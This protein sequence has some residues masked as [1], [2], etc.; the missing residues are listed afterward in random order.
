M[1]VR[2]LEAEAPRGQTVT[3][4]TAAFT[5][6]A[7][8]GAAAIHVEP[9]RSGRNVSTFR[10]S[11]VRD[12]TVL[13]TALATLARPREGALEHH[14]R[15]MPD[16]PEPLATADGPSEHY[17]PPF[18][19]RFSFRQTHGPRPFSGGREARVA[20]WCRLHEEGVPFDA[21]LVCAILDAW[22]P[23][24]VGLS[25]SWCPV[26]SVE[27]TY[28]FFAPLPAISGDAWVFYDAHAGHVSG[29]LAD[30]H[31]TLWTADG[32]PLATSRQLIAL[33]PA[34]PK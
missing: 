17:I 15:P 21:A 18:A 8:E 30:E 33:F 7:T 5:A 2:A 3:T 14:A 1:L 11:L 28:H 10:G 19:R 31:A 24:A 6:P 34:E 4:L 32:R 12:E 20:G 25:P 23:A 27:L 13:A 22:P 16:A 29:G 9:V 26:A